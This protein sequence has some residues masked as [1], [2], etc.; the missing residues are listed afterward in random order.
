M[1]HVIKRVP[2]YRGRPECPKSNQFPKH[3]AAQ[4]NTNAARGPG[5]LTR[6]TPNVLKF[7]FAR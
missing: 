3:P 4:R 5:S 2:N 7:L 1:N 6:H